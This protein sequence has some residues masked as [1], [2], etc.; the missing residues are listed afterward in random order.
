MTIDPTRYYIRRPGALGVF[1]KATGNGTPG[2]DADAHVQINEYGLRGRL[3]RSTDSLKIL[4]V[5][6][7]TV[8][9][10]LLNDADMWTGRL[11]YRLGS[12]A[13]VGNMGRSGTDS[14]HHVLQLEKAITGL[15]RPDAILV[16]CGLNDMLYGAGAHADQPPPDDEAFGAI[17][18]RMTYD[19]PPGTFDLGDVIEAYKQRRSAVEDED[20]LR[21]PPNLGDA[22]VA[23]N[24][25][26]NRMVALAHRVPAHLVLV[27]QPAI[28]KPEMDAAELAHLYAGG[29]GSP[30]RWG[31]PRTRWYTP[32]VLRHMLGLFNQAMRAVAAQRRVGLIDLANELEPEVAHYVDDFHFSKRGADRVAEIVAAGL[33]DLRIG[34]AKVK[35]T[36]RAGTMYPLW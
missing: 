25:N 34:A 1:L 31:D 33:K 11:E 17:P 9:D 12:G 20:W 4:A 19:E 29:I 21:A 7:S 24:A 26:L 2:L 15:P 18:G 27:T 13:W 32:D 35:A 23:Y 16:L 28:W 22:L 3:A 36:K 14:R 30:T 5:G 10:N 8:E 6:G